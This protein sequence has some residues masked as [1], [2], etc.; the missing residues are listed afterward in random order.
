MSTPRFF[1]GGAGGWPYPYA[2]GGA[3]VG[4]YPGG[5]LVG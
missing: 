1:F 4:G 2:P 5:A 3:L